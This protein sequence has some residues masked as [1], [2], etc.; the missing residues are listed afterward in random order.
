MSKELN[1]TNLPEKIYL[2]LG[3]EFDEDEIVNFNSFE[4]VSWCSDRCFNTDVEYVNPK[5]MLEHIAELKEV[6]SEVAN[7]LDERE[8]NVNSFEF[9]LWKIC[10]DALK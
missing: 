1:I 5:A 8:M 2:V 4:G 9:K 10:N 3:D 7:L 6:I